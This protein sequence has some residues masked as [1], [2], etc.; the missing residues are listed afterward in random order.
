MDVLM[1][2][3]GYP[4]EMPMFTRGPGR[5]RGPRHRRRRPAG[6]RAAR[7]RAPRA[8]RPT[9]RSRR[10][11]TRTAPSPPCSTSLRGHERRPRRV[12][13]GADDA[14]SRPASARRSACPGLTVEQTCRSATRGDEGGPRG[15]RHPHA[16]R[17]AHA[18]PPTGAGRRPSEVGYPLIVK[19]IAGAGSLDTY[20]IDDAAELEAAL[21]RLGHVPEV[22]V[23]EFIDG[24]EFTFD[25]ICAGGRDRLRQH[26]LVPAAPARRQAVEW[27]EP[28]D[29]RPAR[30]RRPRPGRRAGHGRS[31][32]RG[33]G[34]RERLHP[35]GVVPQA[36]RRGRLRRDRGP[37]RRALASTDLMNCALRHRPLPRLGRGRVPRH[38]Q[39]ADRAQVQHRDDHQAGPGPGPD[40]A[41]RASTTL[42]A[43]SA[44]TSSTSISC[45][46][47]H[48][49]G[50]GSA[51]VISDGIV[52]VRHPDLATTIEM[53]DR[54]ATELQPLRR[55]IGG[56]RTAAGTGPRA[57][58]PPPSA[59]AAVTP[60]Y[61]WA[62]GLSRPGAGSN[63]T[64][65]TPSSILATHGRPCP[66]RRSDRHRAV[67]PG[68]TRPRP[69]TAGRA[70][71]RRR[72]R[73][74]RIC[75]Q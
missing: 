33:D 66:G 14:A 18:R 50:T 69:A 44:S 34:V 3:P 60:V 22:S 58:P 61:G 48:R 56:R 65:P 26:L 16:A 45:R 35:H 27:I 51:T 41:S 30:P 54:V 21:A 36:R 23:E 9:C 6:R 73:C 53:A 70:R 71:G 72:R 2:S 75:S 12:A 28:A 59:C 20:R 39:P 8:R 55:L 19:P 24:E 42:M 68:R 62:A 13:V 10:G 49:A 37:R 1:L 15:G 17:G 47:G 32:A 67:R 64:Q 31:G 52:V 57:L 40:R 11:P 7:R 25:T 29:D 46:S 38:V 74:R 43:R 5:R 63:G 4:G